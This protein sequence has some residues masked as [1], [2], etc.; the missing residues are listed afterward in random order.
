MAEEL[1]E[2]FGSMEKEFRDYREEF[3]DYRQEFGGFVGSLETT[4]K[5]LEALPREQTKTL[6]HL[7]KSMGKYPKN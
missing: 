1:Q 6:R 2:G 3:R 7:H 5:S 4:E